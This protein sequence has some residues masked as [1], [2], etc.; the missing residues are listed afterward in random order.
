MALKTL[1]DFGISVYGVEDG[2]KNGH[3]APSFHIINHVIYHTSLDTPELAPTKA[4][5][6]RPGPLPRSLTRSTP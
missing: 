5:C 1:T 2:P 6:A 4:M 3:L